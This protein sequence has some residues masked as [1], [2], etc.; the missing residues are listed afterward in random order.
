VYAIQKNGLQHQVDGGLNRAI[1]G[2]EEIGEHVL[3]LHVGMSSR[4]P[5]AGTS[6]T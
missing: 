6:L 2:G 3:D 4:E 1:V 5:M